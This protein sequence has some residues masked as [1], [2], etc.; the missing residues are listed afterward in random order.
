MAKVPV[1]L[2]IVTAV[3]LWGANFN[4]GAVV[5]ESLPTLTAAGSRFLISAALMIL[6]IVW[7]KEWQAY[8]RALRHPLVLLTGFFGIGCFNLLFFFAL[9]LSTPIN[10]AL[11]MAATPL[12]TV[13]V[14][15]LWTGERP[16]LRAKMAIPVA[17]I[18]V[19]GVILGGAPDAPL[20][21]TWG[22]LLMVLA[23][24]S[25]AIY[26]LIARKVFPVGGPL[27]D[28]TAMVTVGAIMT[29]IA[30][31]FAGVP[32]HLP[33]VRSV[34]AMLAMAVG[35]S[36]LTYVFWNEGVRRIGA[37]RAILYMNLVPVFTVLISAATGTLPTILQFVG[38]ALVIGAVLWSSW[39]TAV[40]V[41]PDA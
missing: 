3:F 16:T 35:G 28:A 12:M 17:L 13:I 33:T 7:R 19:V 10:T 20:D 8:L 22:D 9:S 6:M 32:E 29:G 30:A 2:L 26:S 39:P 25:F 5:L 37:S 24:L 41:K 27:P 11:I 15:F 34:V 36:V 38:G 40:P 4:L 31:L 18:G 1:H 21:A 23:N 14:A